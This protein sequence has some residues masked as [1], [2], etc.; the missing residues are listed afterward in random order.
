M[1]RCLEMRIEGE[2]FPSGSEGSGFEGVFGSPVEVKSGTVEMSFEG[3]EGS[4]KRLR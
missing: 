3:S 2:R 4:K 1:S